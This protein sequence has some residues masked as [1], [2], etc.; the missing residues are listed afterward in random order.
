MPFLIL[1]MRMYNQSVV[2]MLSDLV[3]E[4]PSLID[5]IDMDR[6][7][8]EIAHLMEELMADL[9]GNGMSLSHRQCRGHRDTHFCP[10]LMAHSTGLHVRHRLDAGNMLRRMPKLVQD[11]RVHAI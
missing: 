11:G 1:L 2:G 9:F 4:F 5:G 7:T 10:E 6:D 3:M 8:P